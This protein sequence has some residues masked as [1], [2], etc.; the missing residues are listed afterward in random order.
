[1]PKS[2]YATNKPFTVEVCD[3]IRHHIGSRTA[4]E[5]KRKTAFEDRDAAVEELGRIKDES[6]PDLAKAK[7][8]HS[9]AVVL[10]EQL[11]ARIKWHSNQVAEIVEKADEPGFEFMYDMPAEK[12]DDRPVGE[13]KNG[14]PA[15]K[16]AIAGGETPPEGVDEHLAASVN[17]LD[18]RENL[19]GKLVD[20][21]FKTIKDLADFIDS[22]KQ[23]LGSVVEV[24]ENGISEI[25]KALKAYRTKHRAAMREAEAEASG[26]K[27]RGRRGK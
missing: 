1:M 19:K 12:H 2:K 9:D 15:V 11:S 4:L 17:E 7:M 26:E 27:P 16:P 6:S 22:D 10:I 18:C 3:A 5:S 25:K 8:R 14:K 24:G 21:G 13:K 23:P 20:A